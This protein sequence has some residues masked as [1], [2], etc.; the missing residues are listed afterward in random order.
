M[1]AEKL[2]R[3]KDRRADAHMG[4]AKGDGRFKICTHAHGQMR[5]T[6]ARGDLGKKRKMRRRLFALRRDAHQPG[7]GKTMFVSARGDEGIRF[8]RKNTSFLRF[9]PRV[10]LDV[11]YGRG[12]VRARALHGQ[13]GREAGAIEGFDHIKQGKGIRD[14]VGLERANQMQFNIGVALTKVRPFSGSFLNPIFTKHAMAG[15]KRRRDRVNTVTLA[16]SDQCYR[17]RITARGFRRPHDARTDRG[18]ISRDVMMIRRRGN[19]GH[20]G[21]TPYHWNWGPWDQVRAR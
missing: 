2:T 3:T 14:L 4:G 20:S 13:L 18:Q 19:I 11:K 17:L 21:R 9:F 15:L 1:T 6:V 5:Q 12:G 16:N 10:D 8:Y 7:R